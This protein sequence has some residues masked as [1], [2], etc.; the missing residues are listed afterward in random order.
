MRKI[1]FY[2]IICCVV[3]I[4]VFTGCKTTTQTTTQTITTPLSTSSPGTASTAPATTTQT[5]WWDKL[6]TPE[7]GGEITKAISETQTT[8]DPYP[9]MGSD[10]NYQYE[11]MFYPDWTVDRAIWSMQ[12]MFV[13]SKYF[14]GHLAESW[15]ITT[16]TTVTLHLRK[17]ITWQNKPPVNGREFTAEDVVFHYDRLLGTGHGY[18]EGSP[19][20]SMLLGNWEKV[21]MVDKYTVVYYFKSPCS[22]VAFFSMSDQAAV[23]WF[24]APEWVA[25]AGP[26]PVTNTSGTPLADWKNAVGTGPWILNDFVAN[27][28]VTYIKNPDYW[29]NDPRYPNNRTPYADTLKLVVISDSA[30]RLAALRTGKIDI[31][32]GAGTGG[33]DIGW[34]KAQTLKNTNLQSMQM[35]PGDAYGVVFRND[36]APFTDIRVRKALNMAIDRNTIAK[37]L[38]GGTVEGKPTG[39]VT[40]AYKGW[41]Y[42]YEDWPQQLKDEYAYNPQKAKELLAEAGYPNGFKTNVVT[43][44]SFNELLEIYKA[45]FKE[46]NVDMEIRVMDTTTFSSFVRESKHD[47]MAES[48]AGNNWPPTRLIEQFYSKGMDYGTNRVNDPVYDAIRDKFWSASTEEEARIALVEADKR[49]IEQHWGVFTVHDPGYVFWQRYLKGYSGEILFWSQQV[50]WSRIW[51]DNTLKKSMGR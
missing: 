28:S 21:T 37:N 50:L 13:P 22:G 26:A 14:A 25:M 9:F 17:G 46:I 27:T 18:T 10:H 16:P 24:E 29:C 15:E 32:G 51:V 33:I 3:L 49:S 5:H 40:Q 43:M 30:T 44:G 11:P 23:N 48:N 35:T 12:G 47:Q 4:T 6:G 8:F 41:C 38:Y 45:Y 36:S 19:M 7:Y 42:S 39:L 20:A 2:I 31:L 34:Q 1:L